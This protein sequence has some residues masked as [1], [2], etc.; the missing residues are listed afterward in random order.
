MVSMT[1]SE[2][3]VETQ[4]SEIGLE[5]HNETYKSANVESLAICCIC[6]NCSR[7]LKAQKCLTFAQFGA[8]VQGDYGRRGLDARFVP[9][10]KNQT[11]YCP[12]NTSRKKIQLFPHFKY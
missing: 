8:S 9:Q 2:V 3:S 5:K 6:C 1:M 7:G 12:E 10:K 4:T 11:K